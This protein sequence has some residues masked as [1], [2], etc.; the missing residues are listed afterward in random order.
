MI[1]ILYEDRSILVCQKP[2]GV[3]SQAGPGPN[4]PDLLGQEA[5]GTVYP[6]HRL[7]REGSQ[8]LIATHSPIL[9]GLP[10]ADILSFDGEAVHP[11]EYTDTDSYQVTEMFLNHREYL[12]GRL[13]EEAEP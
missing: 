6:I 2:P 13:L 4:L 8:F 1:P 10:K 12:L 3:L 5:G 9:L 7:A 11:V